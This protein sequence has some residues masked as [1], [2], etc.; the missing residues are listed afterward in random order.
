MKDVGKS[1]P[2][3]MIAYEGM[4]LRKVLTDFRSLEMPGVLR[5]VASLGMMARR[6]TLG[7]RNLERRFDE[8]MLD[9]RGLEWASRR[10][11]RSVGT[12]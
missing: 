6:K 9:R 11:E 2:L 3:A 7:M 4:E 12:A 8:W 5:S 1:L 10:A